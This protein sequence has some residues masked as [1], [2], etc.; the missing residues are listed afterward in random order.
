MKNLILTLI[1]CLFGSTAL[2]AQQDQYKWANPGRYAASNAE[3]AAASERPVA[4]FMGNSITD[5]WA[6]TRGEFFAS[7]R[8]VG[9][10]I[11]GQ[12]TAQ[13]L[14]R[15]R[16]DVIELRPRVAVIGG[17][18]NDMAG[19]TGD[20][21]AAFSF[22]NF[23]SMAE[24]AAANGITPILTSILPANVIPWRPDF[25]WEPAQVAAMNECIKAYAAE[26]GYVYVDYYREM[27]DDRQGLITEYTNDGVHVTPA[28]Y[29]VMERLIKAA[30]DKIV[31]N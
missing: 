11:S 22:G 28:G 16:Q 18:I 1:F 6:R 19:K 5:G 8:Y 15:F 29:A 31:A 13:F 17:G 4:V 20:Y 26:K 30:I 14:S 12:T 24:L 9:R 7:N 23:C 25:A 21:D 2:F 10:G 27:V 3:I